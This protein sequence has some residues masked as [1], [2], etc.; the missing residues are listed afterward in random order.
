MSECPR[1]LSKCPR[2]N[3]SLLHQFFLV[4]VPPLAWVLSQRDRLQSQTILQRYDI[5]RKREDKSLFPF[6][7]PLAHNS[8]R[9]PP[10]KL[11]HRQSSSSRYVRGGPPGQ[12]TDA[13]TTGWA[14]NC[15]APS[16]IAPLTWGQYWRLVQLEKFGQFKFSTLRYILRPMVRF[17]WPYSS[18]GAQPLVAACPDVQHKHTKS[19][20]DFNKHNEFHASIATAHDYT[21]TGSKSLPETA[22]SGG[23]HHRCCSLL[24]FGRRCIEKS[25]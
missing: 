22:P 13:Q 17:G 5:L 4:W 21:K 7:S 1:T 18:F 11:A 23:A 19:R 6:F 10:K 8:S 15:H 12:K 24:W 16:Q 14:Q 20:C 9:R 2:T 25:K 3:I